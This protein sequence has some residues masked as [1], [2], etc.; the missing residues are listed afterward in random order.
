LSSSEPLEELFELLEA[1][2]AFAIGARPIDASANALKDQN[3]LRLE[4]R[5]FGFIPE[6]LSLD[7]LFQRKV[8]RTELQKLPVSPSDTGKL[9]LRL[10][11]TCNAWMIRW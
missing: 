4:F 3:L 7:C 2:A 6:I 9:C 8:D 11:M 1:P 5:T 10:K